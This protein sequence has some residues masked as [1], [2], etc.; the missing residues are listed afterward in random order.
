MIGFNCLCD[1]AFIYDIFKCNNTFWKELGSQL[2]LTNADYR[3]NIFTFQKWTEKETQQLELTLRA[4]LYNVGKQMCRIIFITTLEG[5]SSGSCNEEWRGP[6][7]GCCTVWRTA[8]YSF[9]WSTNSI[10]S[11]VLSNNATKILNDVTIMNNENM[12]FCSWFW[13]NLYEWSARKYL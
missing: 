9:P 4:V 13:K 5:I 1:A 3:G 10:W 8:R 6:V 11:R 2:V 7:W 12:T